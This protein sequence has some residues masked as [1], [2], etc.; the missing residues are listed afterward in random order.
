MQEKSIDRDFII[1][2][3][4]QNA[5]DI[6]AFGVSRI[7]LF[8]SFS[9]QEERPD[10]DIDFLVEFKPHQKKYKNFIQ[11]AFYLEDLFDTEID[12]LTKKSLSPHFGPDILKEVEYINYNEIPDLETDIEFIIKNETK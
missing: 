5:N 12:L 6:K 4:Q 9:R 7:G 2:Q 8:G 10:S 1:K 11:L 3:L